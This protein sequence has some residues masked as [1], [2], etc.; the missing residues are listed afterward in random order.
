MASDITAVGFVT[1]LQSL[2]YAFNMCK[3]GTIR[4]SVLEKQPHNSGNTTLYKNIGYRDLIEQFE[5]NI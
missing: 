3:D 1:P 2:H 5:R 4:P